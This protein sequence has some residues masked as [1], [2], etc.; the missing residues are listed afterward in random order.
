MS[1][2]ITKEEILELQ[3]ENGVP[4]H[5]HLFGLMDCSKCVWLVILGHS[6]DPFKSA[7]DA[8]EKDL[9]NE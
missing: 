9:Q 8:I 5:S 6:E 7:I 3:K 2:L 4:Q 1:N